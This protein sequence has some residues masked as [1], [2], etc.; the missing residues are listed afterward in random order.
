MTPRFVVTAEDFGLSR[1]ITDSILET[2]DKGPVRRVSIIGNG[3][4]F[5]SAVAEAKRRPHLK[6]ALHVNL[7]EG[8][9]LSPRH[10]IPQLV[11]A[12]GFFAYAPAALLARSLMSRALSQQIRIEVA[13]QVLRAR[14]ALGTGALLVNGHQHVHLIPAVADALASMEGV[15]AVRNVSEPFYLA[16][17]VSLAHLAARPLLAFLSRRAGRKLALA[18]AWFVGFLYSGRMTAR[19]LAAGLA[20]VRNDGGE[21]LMHPGSALPGELAEWSGDVA[22]HYAAARAAERQLL[23]TTRLENVSAVGGMEWRRVFRFGV[24]GTFA[25]AIDLGAFY[26]LTYRAGVWYLYASVFAFG[27]AFIASFLLQKFWTFADRS[28]ERAHRQAG[29]YLALQLANVV[30]GMAIL[31]I[32][33]RVFGPWYFIGQCLALLVRAALTYTVSS[34]IFRPGAA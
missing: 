11:D 33:V 32:F 8:R 16:G 18:N 17:S 27:V 2:V 15:A 22:W 30:V 24:A 29:A 4:A 26:L 20:S 9:P 5:A 7:T 21:V 6:L 14:E 23:L 10:A 19:A 31:Y 3:S 34:R 13:A 28:V 12:R 1:G 25:A